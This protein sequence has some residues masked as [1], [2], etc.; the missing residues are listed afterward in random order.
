[1]FIWQGLEIVNPQA[2]EKKVQ[3]ANAKY[4]SSTA[5]FVKVEKQLWH[6]W[7]NIF[8]TG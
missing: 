1:M 4:F 5:S 2:A 7:K 3:E 6:K 8:I